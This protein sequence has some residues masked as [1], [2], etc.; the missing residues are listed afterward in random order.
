M[1][2]VLS[3]DPPHPAVAAMHGNLAAPTG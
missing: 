2:T 1:S 3:I